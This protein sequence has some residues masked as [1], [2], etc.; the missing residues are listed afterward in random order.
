MS[1]SRP[2]ATEPASAAR[3][4]RLPES[5]ARPVAVVH[6]TGELDLSNLEDQ[7]RMIAGAIAGRTSVVVDLSGVQFMDASTIGLLAAS[8]SR[9]RAIGGSF[10]VRLPSPLAARVLAICG[11]DGLVV[12]RPLQAAGRVAQTH[13]R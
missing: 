7:R 5:C 12:D 4:A 2:T 13:R 10:A 6:L 11:L 8:A 1:I 3:T 9:V